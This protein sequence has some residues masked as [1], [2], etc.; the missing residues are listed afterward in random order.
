[1]KIDLF[2]QFAVLMWEQEALG[3]FLIT[4][5]IIEM[6]NG[7]LS[8]IENSQPG[9]AEWLLLKSP[10]WNVHW[11]CKCIEWGEV[12]YTLK[13]KAKMEIKCCLKI[14]TKMWNWG[15]IMW[16]ISSHVSTCNVCITMKISQEKSSNEIDFKIRKSFWDIFVT[17][18]CLKNSFEIVAIILCNF[19]NKKKRLN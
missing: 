4:S 17:K 6:M 3:K 14:S 11:N 19:G 12:H 8:E 5:W 2:D 18:L 15:F 16:W 7:N 1:M 13:N 9:D 10:I